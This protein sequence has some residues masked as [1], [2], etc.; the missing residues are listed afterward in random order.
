MVRTTTVTGTDEG[1]IT[2]GSLVITEFQ[3]DPNIVSDTYGEWVEIYNPASYD[4]HLCSGWQFNDFS[5]SGTAQ[6]AWSLPSSAGVVV[7]AKGYVVFGDNSSTSLNGGVTEAYSY[8]SSMALNNSASGD[9]LQ[10][11]FID[12]SSTTVTV[13]KV[14]YG[15]IGGTGWPSRTSGTSIELSKSHL[16]ASSND[17]GSNWCNATT[18]YGSGD[19]GS[20]GVANSCP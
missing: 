19:K 18:T 17:S 16:D 11:Q 13:D 1:L 20:P 7:P 8:G 2:A 3:N 5:G 15:T 10:I 4:L 9:G 6:P 12:P 14:L